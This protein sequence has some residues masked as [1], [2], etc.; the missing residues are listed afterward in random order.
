MTRLQDVAPE[1]LSTKPKWPQRH[2][3]RTSS[4]SEKS[5]V[6]NKTTNERVER[7]IRPTL[8]NFPNS[9]V[10]PAWQPHSL[11]RNEMRWRLANISAAETLFS[12]RYKT[13]RIFIGHCLDTAKFDP[14]FPRGVFELRK[15]CLLSNLIYKEATGSNKLSR[16]INE[17]DPKP[18]IASPSRGRLAKINLESTTIMTAKILC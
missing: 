5:S 1:D 8:P 11:P 14:V 9:R 2:A 18:A 4:K 17:I 7:K 3:K 12:R 13:H 10:F 6:R 15:Q 16:T